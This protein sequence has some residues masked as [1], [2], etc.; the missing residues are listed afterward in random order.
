[1]SDETLKTYYIWHH[2]IKENICFF[3]EFFSPDNNSK[4]CGDCKMEFKSCSL[5]KNHNFLLH[6]NQV[7]GSK[8]NRQLPIN[9]LRHG[10]IVYYTINFI[11]HKNFY[12]FY[13]ES[14]VD[15]FLNSVH[16]PFVSAAE[17]KIQGYAKAINY[18]QTE[19][20]NIENTRVWLTNVYAT[21]YFNTYARDEIKNDILKRIIFNEATGSSWIFRRFNSVTAFEVNINIPTN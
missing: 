6:Y 8:I 21:R 13:Q 12:E 11:Q 10:P 7:R 19:V 9:V 14:V 1:M 16:E 5:K 17:D 3:R 4:R 2:S 18:Q 20:V 15:D